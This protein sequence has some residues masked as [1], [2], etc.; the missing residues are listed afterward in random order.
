MTYSWRVTQKGDVPALK[1][2]PW[3]VYGLAMQPKFDAI[4]HHYNYCFT[5]LADGTPY[6]VAGGYLSFPGVLDLF[7][8]SDESAPR[9]ACHAARVCALWLEVTEEEGVRRQQSMV[10]SAIGSSCR[11]LKYLGFTVEAQLKNYYHDS[12]ALLFARVSK[13]HGRICT[14]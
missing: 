3:D 11:L 13:K 14:T 8:M 7:I 12:D 10:P 9:H 4:L 5:A 6:I 1:L 2:R